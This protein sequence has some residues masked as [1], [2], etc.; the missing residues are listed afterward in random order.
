MDKR[1][2]YIVTSHV[3][4]NSIV[5]IIQMKNDISTTQT[6]LTRI[7]WYISGAYELQTRGSFNS[8]SIS[9]IPKPSEALSFP[10]IIFMSA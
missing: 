2:Y 4:N 10:H 5:A 1:S 9:T 8:E 7:L 3:N 6:S